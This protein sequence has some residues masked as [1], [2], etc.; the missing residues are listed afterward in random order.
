[1]NFV[2]RMFAVE[3][4]IRF[5]LEFLISTI[6][7][8]SSTKAAKVRYIVQELHEVSGEFLARTAPAVGGPLPTQEQ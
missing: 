3:T 5:V 6:K 7:N 2:L 1:M 4:L 8:P